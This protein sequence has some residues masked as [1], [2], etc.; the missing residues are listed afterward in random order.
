VTAFF[1]C[2]LCLLAT[3]AIV[4]ADTGPLPRAGNPILPG[5]YADPSV[6]QVDGMVYI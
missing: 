1:V 6:V 5:Y 3:S 4:A 2:L